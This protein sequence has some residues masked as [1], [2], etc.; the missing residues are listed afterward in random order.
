MTLTFYM[1]MMYEELKLFKYYS[2][3]NSH[4]LNPLLFLKLPKLKYHYLEICFMPYRFFFFLT[5]IFFLLIVITLY[6]RVFQML[7]YS[8]SSRRLVLSIYSRSRLILSKAIPFW[9]EL[10]VVVFA[11]GELSSPF[12]W[13]PLTTNLPRHFFS[14]S[15]SS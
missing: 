13:I 15:I 5:T 8:L 12:C 11:N 6:G 10:I 3:S 4:L 1:S 7:P 14:W 9:T 2:L